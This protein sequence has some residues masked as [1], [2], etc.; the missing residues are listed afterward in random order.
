MNT[1]SKTTSPTFL[2][3][4]TLLLVEDDPD[5]QRLLQSP[6]EKKVGRLLQAYNGEEGLKIFQKDP[7][8][9]IITDV[10]MP[11]MNG[12]EMSRKIR[13][14]DPDIPIIITTA[15]ND[16]TIFLESIDLGIDRFVLKPTQHQTLVTAVEKC[17]Y[18]LNQRRQ[19]EA[20]HQYVHFLLDALPT[21]LMVI[22]D[23]SVEY[24]NKAF[25][26]YLGFTSLAALKKYLPNI[27][28][29][30][31]TRSGTLFSQL[32]D[33]DWIEHLLKD[34]KTNAIIYLR[35]PDSED[36]KDTPFAV[37]SNTLPTHG[38]HLFTF[39]DVTHIEDEK[40][41]L[42]H[43]A[44][45]DP[46]T[47]ACNRAKLESRLNTEIQR[48]QRHAIPLSIILCDLDHFKSVN[49]TYGHQVGDDVLK[50]A[51]KL[52]QANIRAEDVIARW[53]GEEFMVVSPQNDLEQTQTLAEKLRALIEITN[54]P[55]AGNITSSF[56]VAQLTPTDTIRTLTE[57]ADKALYRSKSKG[58]NRVE[59][60]MEVDF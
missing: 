17:A 53:G 56:G 1:Q 31:I 29:I 57:R 26:R 36:G 54:F 15:H 22:S 2:K 60:E 8:D 44:F 12:L 51:V 16:D 37:T 34:T 40:R 14:K 35:R 43:Q 50:K 48:A 33:K 39:S 28:D 41:Q 59:I 9:I 10:Q 46:L 49:D 3:T 55:G 25:L 23:N 27:G 13:D 47:G 11:I 32:G 30:L 42:E 21:F 6:L 45:T 58:R 5:I 52:I 7:P 19:Q 18:L 4:L 24:I 38:K 20:S